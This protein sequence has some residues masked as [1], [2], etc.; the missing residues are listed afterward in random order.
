M[1][2]IKFNDIKETVLKFYNKDVIN[3][4]YKEFKEGYSRLLLGYYT[5]LKLNENDH[6]EY[7]SDLVKIEFAYEDD[8]PRDRDY[9]KILEL[10]ST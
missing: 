5:A 3:Y 8:N 4:I 10:M 7:I 9:N 1:I 6:T 2:V